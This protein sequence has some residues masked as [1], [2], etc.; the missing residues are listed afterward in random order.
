[1]LNVRY[2]VNLIRI[3]MMKRLVFVLM[4]SAGLIAQEAES[5]DREPVQLSATGD[6]T[7]QRKLIETKLSQPE[8]VELDKEGRAELDRHFAALESNPGDAQAIAGA[9]AVLKKVFADSR[10]VC[11]YE[12]AL[13]SN[14]KKRQCMT[15]AARKRTYETTQQTLMGR[16]SNDSVHIQGN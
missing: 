13:G 16:D 10:M 15:A 8:Y 12:Q 11:T 7:G 1:M 2:A 5:A 14:M 9:N 3:M 4:L 6:I